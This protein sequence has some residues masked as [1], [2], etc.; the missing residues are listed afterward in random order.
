M[1]YFDVG[2]A[3]LILSAVVYNALTS[4]NEA[5]VPQ[6]LKGAIDCFNNLLIERKDKVVPAGAYAEG[7]QL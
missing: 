2:V 5:F 1:I 7:A 3:C 6:A 4:V